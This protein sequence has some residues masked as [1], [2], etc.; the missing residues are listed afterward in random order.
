MSFRE[1]LVC[2]ALISLC[3]CAAT[4][5]AP[6][7]AMYDFDHKSKLDQVIHHVYCLVL[8]VLQD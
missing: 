5:E 4:T 1:N 6:E 8:E 7:K 3:G 2:L